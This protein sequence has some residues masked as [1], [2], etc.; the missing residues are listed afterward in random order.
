M[1]KLI[2]SFKSEK[3]LI[4]ILLQQYFDEKAI[5][6]LDDFVG[7]SEVDWREFTRLIFWHKITPI[8]YPMLKVSSCQSIPEYILFDIRSHYHANA[9]R[10]LMLTME[11]FRII[12]ILNE[13]DIFNI[14]FKGPILAKK[15]YANFV[16]RESQDIDILI[17]QRDLSIAH[18]FLLENGYQRIQPRSLTPKQDFYYVKYKND[19][20]YYQQ[21]LNIKLELHW[22]FFDFPKLFNLSVDEIKDNYQSEII[23]GVSIKTLA[24]Q[25][26]FLYLFAHGATSQW[27]RLFWLCDIMQFIKHHSAMD[28][29]AMLT[30]SKKLGMQRA[31]LEGYLMMQL[32]FLRA[33]P[34]QMQKLIHQDKAVFSLTKS[35]LTMIHTSSHPFTSPLGMLIRYFK[36]NGSWRYR[37]SL[38]KH[39]LMMSPADWA[40]LKLPDAFF[41]LYSILRL[42]TWC[43]RRIKRSKMI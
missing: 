37:F 21:K 20:V 19:F 8:I 40:V 30:Y 24:E 17:H 34:S 3:K 39:R 15:L 31:M 7:F 4:L 25:D 23:S 2:H 35:S 11:L 12:N 10:M 18:S 32:L 14:T 13:A 29:V 28:P 9:K 33:L 26:E 43:F 42:F 36:L 41:F 1:N 27:F 22:R 38:I 5:V 6:S 16:M